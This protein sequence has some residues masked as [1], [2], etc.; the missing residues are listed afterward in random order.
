MLLSEGSLELKPANILR[1]YVSTQKNSLFAAELKE[2]V[3]DAVRQYQKKIGGQKFS[4]ATRD[5]QLSLIPEFYHQRIPY[6]CL[7]QE[8]VYKFV[9]LP[10]RAY[11]KENGLFRM[12][13]LAPPT[14]SVPTSVFRSSTAVSNA[15]SVDSSQLMQKGRFELG[16]SGVADTPEQPS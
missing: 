15:R 2:L 16:L 6:S 1:Q 12:G 9:T 10:E 7:A 5:T 4:K 3:D 14:S 11:G 8:L 13:F